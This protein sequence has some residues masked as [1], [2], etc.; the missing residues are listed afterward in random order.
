MI[1]FFRYHSTHFFFLNNKSGDQWLAIDAGWPCTFQEYRHN[2]KNLN[3]KIDELTYLIVTHFH[4]D[5]AGLLGE[6]QKTPI[7]PLVLDF[8]LSYIDDMERTILKNKDYKEYKRIDMLGLHIMALENLNQHLAQTGFPVHVET[9]DAH[10][11][12]HICLITDQGEAIIGD[13]P[14]INQI[15]PDDEKGTE[16]WTRIL[17]RGVSVVYPSHAEPF[18]P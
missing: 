5:H 18:Y 2:L 14:P 10:S 17:S 15:M 8:Q 13:L 16:N 6:L 7:V 9:A 12:D 4:L 11:P 1:K 3:I